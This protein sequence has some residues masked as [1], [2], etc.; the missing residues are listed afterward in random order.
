VTTSAD[1]PAGTAGA[2]TL[3]GTTGYL[4][5]AGPALNTTQS[6]TVSAWA[7]LT[8]LATTQT[9]LSQAT[10][11]HQAFYLGY[12]SSKS[13][14]Y[15]MT[16]TS[17]AATTTF[18][19]AYGGTATAGTWTH[20][21]GVYDADSNI[22]SLYVNGTLASS[23]AVNTT[24]VYNSTAPLTIGANLTL[25]TTSLYNQVSGSISD[26]RAFPAALTQDEIAH[27]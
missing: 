4:R 18:P 19:H 24:P 27:L 16:T 13:A 23:A 10:I 8:S 20:I 11:K 9:V 5:T 3:N 15:F 12:S 17:D 14:W 7:K 22:M 1:H 25:G 21:T 26:V 2:V 6:Y